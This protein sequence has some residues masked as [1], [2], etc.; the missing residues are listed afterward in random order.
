MAVASL[1]T[2]T[3]ILLALPANW[4]DAGPTEIEK[5]KALVTDE[6]TLLGLYARRCKV[7]RR[8]VCLTLRNWPPEEIVSLFHLFPQLEEVAVSGVGCTSG[9]LPA[10]EYPFV[11]PRTVRHLTLE[12]VAFLHHSVEAILSPGTQ[13]ESLQLL[14]LLRGH[15]ESVPSVEG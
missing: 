5:V 6:V 12:R 11:L 8:A 9:N 3:H 15:I 4:Q 14:S 1:Q 7:G 10:I 13:L 2:H